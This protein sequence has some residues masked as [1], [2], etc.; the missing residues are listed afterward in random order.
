MFWSNNTQDSTSPVR[1]PHERRTGPHNSLK[2]FSYPTR[3]FYRAH[4]GPARVPLGTLTDTKGNWHNQNLQKSRTGVVCGR[5][6]PVWTLH[7]SR[8]GCLRSLNPYGAR[9][10][11][12]HALKLYGPRTGRQNLYGAARVPYGPREWTDD[13][14]SKQPGNSP[15]GAR[16]CDVTGAWSAGRNFSLMLF[17]W[18]HQA[19]GPRTASDSCTLTFL[20]NYKLQNYRGARVV[21]ARAS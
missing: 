19:Y 17:S 15:Y 3:D 20:S 14:C 18:S 12:M 5:T 1:C 8:T 9:R 6:G 21:P 7:G 4:A 11:I 10:L 16:E 13:V 2:C